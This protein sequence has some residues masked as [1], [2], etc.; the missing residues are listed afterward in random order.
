MTVSV[1]T[2][3][4]AL[5]AL[6][7][8]NQTND[9][10][11]VTQNRINTGLKVATAKDDASTYA[12]AQGQRADT[13]AYGAVKNSLNRASSIADVAMAAGESISDLLNQISAKVKEAMDPSLQATSRQAITDDFRALTRQIAQVLENAEFDGANLLNGAITATAGLRFLANADADETLTLTPKN[14]SF[15]GAIISFTATAT[16]ST[17]TLAGLVSAQVDAS[18]DRVNLALASIGAQAKQVEGHLKFVGK[19]SDALEV[20]LG[21]L[22]D[23]DMAKESSRLAALQVQQQLGAQA[24]SIA[25][26]QPQTILSLFRN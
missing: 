23:A 14:M 22:V 6:Q 7:S 8:L 12:I 15:G 20:G 4:S 1:N 24:L 2:N 21:N 17:S 16:I 25:N 18:I 13:A 5:T 26:Q 19:L 3:R 11:L 9:R 10:L